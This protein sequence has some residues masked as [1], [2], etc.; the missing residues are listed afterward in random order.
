MKK[1]NNL[2]PLLSIVTI[3]YND[4]DELYKTIQSVKKQTFKDF[5]YI[6]IDGGSNDGSLNLLEENEKIIDY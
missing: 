2:K 3:S 5:E 1:T 4:C 6:I